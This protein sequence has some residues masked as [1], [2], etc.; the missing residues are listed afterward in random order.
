M[1][2]QDDPAR[3]TN[4]GDNPYAA[5]RI[6]EGLTQTCK[7]NDTQA[8]TSVTFSLDAV[9]LKHFEAATSYRVVGALILTLFAATVLSGLA[10]FVLALPRVIAT[11]QWPLL[12]PS[13]TPMLILIGVPTL[14]FVRARWRKAGE[15][16]DSPRSMTVELTSEG[17]VVTEHGVGVYKRAWASVAEVRDTPHLILL[18]LNEHNPLLGRNVKVTAHLV[19]RRAFATPEAADSFLREARRLLARSTAPA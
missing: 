6:S 19:P 17:L 18:V 7:G 2:G 11:G 3:R 4:G 1:T 16:S 14:M 5:P 8:V 10:L 9:D 15:G 12:Y 13:I